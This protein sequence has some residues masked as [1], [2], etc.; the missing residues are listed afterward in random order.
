MRQF[1]D[2]HAKIV[3]MT[4]DIVAGNPDHVPAGG[5]N[6]SHIP[7]ESKFHFFGRGEAFARKKQNDFRVPLRAQLARPPTPVRQL[8]SLG[9]ITG[10]ASQNGALGVGCDTGPN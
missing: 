1:M 10:D 3:L 4:V 6:P 9:G 2:H 7:D 8:G 5:G